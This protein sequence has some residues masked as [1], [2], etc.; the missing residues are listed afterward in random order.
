MKKK[1]YASPFGC[2]MNVAT[3]SFCASQVKPAHVL[4]K[5]EDQSFNGMVSPKQSHW[6]KHSADNFPTKL[7]LQNASI[8]EFCSEK[9]SFYGG[10]PRASRQGE[11]RVVNLPNGTHTVACYKDHANP[12]RTIKPLGLSLDNSL[13]LLATNTDCFPFATSVTYE[14]YKSP[15]QQKV[16]SS[17]SE[18]IVGD[19]SDSPHYWGY[20]KSA[21]HEKK[22]QVGGESNNL[23]NNMPGR[24][25]YDYFPVEL[26]PVD[27]SVS[28]TKMNECRSPKTHIRCADNK[29]CS[30]VTPTSILRNYMGGISPESVLRSIAMTYKNVPSIIRKRTSRKACN[31]D[32]SDSD[33]NT[34]ENGCLYS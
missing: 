14:A 33:Q 27:D 20:S 11:R 13:E 5:V 2:D 22:S 18:F 17:D 1:L 32:Y 8:E 24:E 7:I 34:F 23:F 30:Y 28:P 4:V 6:L 9:S 19:E 25:E 26:P 21:N 12:T 29:G 3:S 31:A 16:S 15:K 10:T